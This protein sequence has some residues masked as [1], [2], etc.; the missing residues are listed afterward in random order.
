MASKLKK[1]DTCKTCAFVQYKLDVHICKRYPP[2]ALVIDNRAV[3]MQVSVGPDDR[4][5]GEYRR[6]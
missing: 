6:N 5:C 3:T 2:A 1:P 4:A